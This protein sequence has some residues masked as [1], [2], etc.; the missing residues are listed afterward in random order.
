MWQNLPQNA[1]PWDVRAITKASLPR[2]S[3]PS[4]HQSATRTPR[5]TAPTCT[6]RPTVRGTSPPGGSPQTPSTLPQKPEREE[7]KILAALSMSPV[8]LCF[9]AMRQTVGG[10][11]GARRS[12]L[13]VRKA[14]G[15]RALHGVMDN[16]TRK[17]HFLVRK[18]IPKPVC[19]W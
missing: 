2:D 1:N 8:C 15:W 19:Y 9:G 17:I 16:S 18:P 13:G 11:C 5:T 10:V 4:R 6:H 7:N 14:A 12:R 3:A